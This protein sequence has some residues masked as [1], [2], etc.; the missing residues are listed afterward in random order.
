L[1]KIDKKTIREWRQSH[2]KR[3]HPPSIAS[4]ATARSDTRSVAPSIVSRFR[5]PVVEDKMTV[6][7]QRRNASQFVA[8]LESTLLNGGNP[9]HTLKQKRHN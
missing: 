7:S 3:Y 1:A 2:P 6:K 4:G 5:E 8:P 9:V